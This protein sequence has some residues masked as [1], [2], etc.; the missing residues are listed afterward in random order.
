VPVS[1][2]EQA[3]E[4]MNSKKVSIDKSGD[5]SLGFS[6]G[7]ENFSFDFKNSKEGLVLKK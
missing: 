5:I 7:N 2:V 6:K 4:I 3:K 1:S